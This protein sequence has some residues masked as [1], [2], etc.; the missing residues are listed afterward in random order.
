MWPQIRALAWVHFRS[1]RNRFPRTGWGTILI[2]FLSLLWYG[3]FVG[4]GTLLAFAL[5]L[6]DLKTLRIAIPLALIA[7][8][9]YWQIFPLATLSGGWSLQMGKLRVYPI[10]LSALFTIEVFLRL[11]TAPEA[12]A[13]LLGGVIG[14]ARHP[15]V[16]FAGAL[17]LLLF[18]PFNLFLLIG[19]R[20]ALMRSGRN[21]KFRELRPLI[22]ILFAITPQFIAR[23]PIRDYL[24]PYAIAVARVPATPWREWT[25]LSLGSFSLLSVLSV[26]GWLAAAYYFARWQFALSLREDELVSLPSSPASRKTSW[27]DALWSLPD[28]LT[29]DPLAALLQK[30]FRSL[31]RMPRFRVLFGLA[32]VFSVLVFLPMILRGGRVGFIANNFLPIVNV[33]GMLILSEVMVFNVFGFDRKAV[34]IYLISPAPFEIVLKAKNLVALC[35]IMLQS[36]SVI[37]IAALFRIRVTP[38]DAV[39]ALGTTLVIT[40]F[41]MCAGNLA[42]VH[43][44]RP[45]DPN[46]TFRR[47]TGGKLQLWI[48]GSF[49]GLSVPIGF[50]FLARWA[51][52]TEWAYLGV[53]AVDLVIGW[54]VYRLSLES[55]VKRALE[56]TEDLIDK[57]SK[58]GDPVGT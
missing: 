29:R 30:E 13:V 12:I 50:A 11:T 35:F 43:M 49:I 2:W 47:Q 41:L 44:P 46:Q 24:K 57:L 34:Q 18:I 56:K 36:A 37:I 33:Y 16:P 26:V 14:L 38:I 45:T 4:L 5:P 54:I 31:V 17:A 55:A 6:I 27:L 52:N 39:N 25:A 19:L 1:M 48:M 9:I 28:R 22:F 32:C 8:M 3:L 7:I 23:P 10:K 20:E 40:L 21:K 51:F 53:L 42:S 58:G 15:H